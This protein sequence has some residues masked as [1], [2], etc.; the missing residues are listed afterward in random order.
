MYLI[1]LAV[2][3]LSLAV[4]FFIAAKKFPRLANLDV[5]NLP[6]EKTSRKKKEI[7]N[8]R[9]RL[10]AGELKEKASKFTRPLKKWWGILQLRFRIY[11]GKIER[12]WYHEQTIKEQSEA[13][14]FSAEERQQKAQKLVQK[15]EQQL[16]LGSAEKAEEIFI[17]AVKLE[18]KSAVAY[19]G[20]ADTYLARNSIEE[21]RETYRFV[22]QLEPDDDSVLVKLAEI[23]ESQGD[24]EEAIQY[25]QR[26]VMVNDSLSP[27]F[28]HL[29]ELLVKVGHPV[30]AKEAVLQAVELEPQNPKYLDLL[31]EIAIL[32]N[33]KELAESG[34]N[35]LRLVNAENQ[36]LDMFKERIAK[37]KGALSEE[38]VP[39]RAS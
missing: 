6:E 38:R 21:A 5:Q 29:A 15:A 8:K 3:V 35:Q 24:L 22:L 36:K 17:S 25:Y 39:S 14:N 33:D 2:I 37:L 18:P 12:L 30:V 13:Q 26:A 4:I 27:R 28:Y 10:Q 31:V 7:I 9:L 32:C 11:I 1:P 34:Y 19:R 16:K 20:L 23:A